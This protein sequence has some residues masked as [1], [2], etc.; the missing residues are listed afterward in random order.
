MYDHDDMAL[1]IALP[2]GAAALDGRLGDEGTV[3]EQEY[4]AWLQAEGLMNVGASDLAER[5]PAGEPVEVAMLLSRE[6]G[7][8][9]TDLALLE[10]IPAGSVDDVH[11][12]VA[13]LKRCDRLVARAQALR[14]EAVVAIAGSEPSGA[15]LPEVHLEH[16]VAVAS[17]TSRHAA[18]KA[19]ETARALVTTFPTF[20]VAL[21]DGEISMGH[22]TVL[23]DRTRVVV[24]AEALANI[25]RVGLT[26]ARRMSVGEF[27]RELAAL[28]ARFDPDAEGRAARAREQRRVSVTKLDDGLGFFGLVHDWSVVSALFAQVT[29]DAKVMQAQRRAEAATDAARDEVAESGA[30]DGDADELARAAGHAAASDVARWDDDDLRLD[31]CRADALAARVLGGQPAAV[32]PALAVD[33]SGLVPGS[34]VADLSAPTD[35]PGDVDQPG[36]A[37]L[38]TPV[39]WN[40]DPA[41]ELEVQLV[42]DLATL[43]GEVENPCLLDGSP[44]PAGI[45]RE[46]ASYAK[47]F[48]R[49][50][51][52]PVTGHLLDYG[53]RTYLPRPLRDYVGA[54][55]GGCRAPGCTTSAA[56]RMQMD[57]AVPFPEGGS[58]PSNTH[59]LCTT[60]HQLK[61][62]GLA[63]L[64]DL[65][66]DGSATWVTAWGQS[67][68]VPPRSF[69]P[70]VEPLPPP[71]EVPP[72]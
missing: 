72:F 34:D 68:W 64:D 17:R 52:D 70:S 35:R 19:I 21:A 57:H 26:R 48:R 44:I 71:P 24:D 14:V 45:G 56:S 50:V 62:A 25:E 42:I 10:S 46:L 3:E 31:T 11:D 7:A 51:T 6:G 58:D 66:P 47:V 65:Q 38:D 67:V 22:C 20:A 18:G 33:G 4:V 49:M 41:A 28:I 16:E 23:V 30:L 69:L 61:T 60:C 9:A 39:V 59:L 13:Y 27:G 29:V 40:R 12:L 53:S 43:R 8:S 32:E 1:L 36:V 54:R 37:P 15:Y 55:D 63:D 5:D 2:D